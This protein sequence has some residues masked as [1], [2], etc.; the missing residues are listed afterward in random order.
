MS[1]K[2]SRNPQ[3]GVPQTPL[4][5]DARR[6]ATNQQARALPWICGTNRISVTWLTDSFNVRAEPVYQEVSKKSDPVI[7]GY[8]YTIGCA[9]L[10]CGGPVDLLQEIWFNNELVWSGQM[11]R[12]ST[13]PISVTVAGHGVMT[14]YWGT[15]DQPLD[16]TL[17]T[18]DIDPDPKIGQ[19]LHSAYRGQCYFVFPALFLG[20]DVTTAPNIEFVVGRYP[21][22]SWLG[23]S[24]NLQGD[25]NAVAMLWDVLCNPVQGIGLTED[26]LD[27]TG[28]A[29][30]ASQLD[31]EC[32][33]FSPF[34][35]Q[36]QAAKQLAMQVADYINCFIVSVLDTT[37][38]K[39]KIGIR[40]CR[41]VDVS[42]CPVF[43]ESHLTA[44]PKIGESG[45]WY[46]TFSDALVTFQNRDIHF[47]QDFA[48]ATD[49]V[50]RL[51]TGLYNQQTLDRPWVTR[52]AVAQAMANTWLQRASLP[53]STSNS[54]ELRQ[55]AVGGLKV[56]DVFKL[57]YPPLQIA[58]RVCRVL[59]INQNR[60]EDPSVTVE[61]RFD[62]P[63][64]ASSFTA[65]AV[66]AGTGTG[67]ITPVPLQHQAIIQM[68]PTGLAA[69]TAQLALVALAA[70]PNAQTTGFNIQ[71][72]AGAGGYNVVTPVRQFASFGSLNRA[73]IEDIMPDD[74]GFDFTLEA[75]DYAL[76]PVTFDDAC[77]DTLLLIVGDEIV[78]IYDLTLVSLGRYTARALRG[79][80]DTVA[81][82][83]YADEACWVVFR[84]VLRPFKPDTVASP[85]NFK[86][87]PFVTDG[88]LVLDLSACQAIPALQTGRY[89][90]PM[91]PL[92]LAALSVQPGTSST[93]LSDCAPP[94]VI[95]GETPG[96]PFS[97]GDVL[98]I[99]AYSFKVSGGVKYFSSTY[100]ETTYTVVADNSWVLF[101]TSV[102]AGTAGYR[103]ATGI[104]G[105]DIV[106]IVDFDMSTLAGVLPWPGTVLGAAFDGTPALPYTKPLTTPGI[107]KL[108]YWSS[109]DD[110]QLRWDNC[111]DRPSSWWPSW[112]GGT[113][114]DLPWTVVILSNSGEAQKKIYTLR[115]GVS[116]LV[117]PNGD[118]QV[119][120]GFQPPSG[121][122]VP[123]EPKEAIV[124][125]W[126]MRNGIF[127]ARPS[128][129]TM[130]KV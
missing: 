42:G 48:P 106:Q 1:L 44:E 4:G 104:N 25:I 6:L 12:S 52:A 37:S 13:D 103:L 85:H 97:A 82:A 54:I 126:H 7:I 15:Y 43:D 5:Q 113:T 112:L 114:D 72:E 46:E 87:Q 10:V 90:S 55:D 100:A 23:V 105:G 66:Q 59:S 50:N 49:I 56:G 84:S 2:G 75:P 65:P 76:T 21:A 122:L 9:G 88:R 77:K 22:P 68:P 29:A 93:S 26:E 98:V 94:T 41:A 111:L 33:G 120:Y 32:L 108:A 69:R 86:L 62:F 102:V 19:R 124:Q 30:V 61:F 83:H 78:S 89:Q 3:V 14:F 63:E 35:T 28:L 67:V 118:I 95:F 64:L 34:S 125:V 116:E 53:Q 40:L 109:G 16:A 99:R 80:F 60:P 38:E 11:W 8:D 117:V 81:A 110:W 18:Q 57:N 121:P 92:N 24:G 130:I 51:I 36:F 58:W 70:R 101:S 115:P 123:M 91:P 96:G 71:S 129:L 20:K 119:A 47:Q 127:S 17:A 128:Q 45:S 73:S 107:T 27:Q 74:Y 31:N 39:S 79:R